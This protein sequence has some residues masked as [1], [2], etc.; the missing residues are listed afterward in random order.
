V[1][2][3]PDPGTTTPPVAPEVDTGI[4]A[5]LDRQRERI[6]ACAPGAQAVVLRARW[7]TDGEVRVSVDPSWTASQ[8]IEPCVRGAIGRMR[9]TTGV[10]G[11]IVHVV[12]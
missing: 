12:R 8:T 6:L 1:I 11:E 9:V 7:E 4:R 2:V 5:A 3:V 10:P